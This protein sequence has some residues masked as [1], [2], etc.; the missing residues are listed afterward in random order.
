M[1]RQ[2][3]DHEGRQSRMLSVLV[4]VLGLGFVAIGM[5]GCC[6]TRGN[7]VS[8]DA[9]PWRLRA[10]SEFEGNFLWRQQMTAR[11]QGHVQEFEAV[12]QKKGD[13]LTLLGLT[14]IGTKAFVLTQNGTEVSFKS[15]INR[16]F[17]FPPHFM[18]IDIQRSY[19]PIAIPPNG[20]CTVTTTIDGERVTEM[21]EGGILRRRTFTRIDGTPQ[22][23]MMIEYRAWTNGTPVVLVIDNQWFGY[24]MEIRTNSLQRLMQ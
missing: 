1:F 2:I 17:P 4:I 14:P 24:T 21:W 8:S 10:A 18:I 3:C 19:Y 22:G 5:G 6:A 16:D 15:F 9:Y 7:P 11:F 23:T 13:T 20:D 12:L